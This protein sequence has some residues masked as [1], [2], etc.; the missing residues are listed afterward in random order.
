LIAES[1]VAAFRQTPSSK[2]IMCQEVRCKCM[3]INNFD[4]AVSRR[5]VF[6][7]TALESVFAWHGWFLSY[8]CGRPNQVA[9]S[10]FFGVYATPQ[11]LGGAQDRGTSE[12]VEAGHPG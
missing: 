9:G 7:S 3:S 10:Y 8:K 2:S 11:R 5:S 6:S 4:R 12:L 1:D